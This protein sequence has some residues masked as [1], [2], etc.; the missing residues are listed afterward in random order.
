MRNQRK[1]DEG[2]SDG[3]VAFPGGSGTPDMIRRAEKAGLKV[4]KPYC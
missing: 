4:W 2:K 1:I 3:L